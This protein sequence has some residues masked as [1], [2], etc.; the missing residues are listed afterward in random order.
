[1]LVSA[2]VHQLHSTNHSDMGRN[3]MTVW[4]AKEKKADLYRKSDQGHFWMLCERSLSMLNES[5]EKMI[6]DD[7]CVYSCANVQKSI[8][9]HFPLVNWS[10]NDHINIAW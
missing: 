4:T 8:F 7:V 1:M 10:W 3:K 5:G 2:H 9:G 6:G